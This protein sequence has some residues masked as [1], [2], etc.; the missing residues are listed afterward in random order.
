[1]QERTL[2]AYLISYALIGEVDDVKGVVILA[3]D[4]KE[5]GI[6]FTRWVKAKRIYERV[7]GVVVQTTRKTKKNAYMFTEDRYK[8]Q[9]EAITRLEQPKA[10]A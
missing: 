7:F 6:I 4:K 8:K 2:K 10:D 1:M 5:A 9:Y 3:Y